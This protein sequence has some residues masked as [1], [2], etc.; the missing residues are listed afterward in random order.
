[1]EE[2]VGALRAC[3]AK[4]KMENLLDEGKCELFFRLYTRLCEENEKYNLTAVTDEAGVILKHFADSAA[5]AR[6]LPEGASLLD[7]GCGAGFPSLPLAVLRP[8]LKI[9]ALD[10]TAKRVQYVTDTAA[11]LGLSNVAG[12]TARAEEH[13]KTAARV[14]FDFVT[15]RAVAN[16]RALSELCLPFVRVGGVFLSMKATGARQELED[17]RR[18]IG[19]LGGKIGTTEDFTLTD[20]AETLSRTAILVKKVKPTDKA[21]PRAWAKILKKPL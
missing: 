19:A 1:M 3:F 18:A 21:Y 5:C 8:D 15:A 2:F 4:C 13:A 20:G 9:T 11:L 6:Y 12:V 10:A 17:A 14:S 7:V 16:L